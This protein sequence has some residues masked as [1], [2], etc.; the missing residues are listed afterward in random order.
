MEGFFKGLTE[1]ISTLMNSDDSMKKLNVL[2]SLGIN[3]FSKIVNPETLIN[4]YMNGDVISIVIELE[5]YGISSDD[6]SALLDK[7][8]KMS[9]T[10]INE[11]S[12]FTYAEV[13]M[14]DNY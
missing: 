1:N 12:A 7:F 6:F 10:V 2:E 5:S 9:N 4:C 13:I 3:I 14:I 8:N 11:N